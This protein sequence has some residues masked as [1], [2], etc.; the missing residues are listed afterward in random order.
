V[1]NEVN[2]LNVDYLLEVNTVVPFK[3]LRWCHNITEYFTDRI[4][5]VP[6]HEN[7]RQILKVLFSKRLDAE[8]FILYHFEV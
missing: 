3:E 4:V 6:L 7:Q 1:L 8:L 5:D 2:Q